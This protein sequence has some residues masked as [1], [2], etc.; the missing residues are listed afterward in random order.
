[1]KRMTPVAI[2]AIASAAAV[3]I[4]C[5]DNSPKEPK[6]VWGEY[7]GQ[8]TELVG[9]QCSFM[10]MPTECVDATASRAELTKL[11]SDR[12]ANEPI[13]SN[14]E[15]ALRQISSINQ[16]YSKFT[17]GECGNYADTNVIKS[18]ASRN[19]ASDAD[20]VQDYFATLAEIT[21]KVG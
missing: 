13:T 8:L 17:T 21:E 7:G 9:E 5:S 14:V 16:F 6:T 20:S 15:A 4:S 3:L 18:Q 11:V 2:A 19:C 12:L 1:M 10:S